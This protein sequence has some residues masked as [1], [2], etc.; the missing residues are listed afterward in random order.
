MNLIKLCTGDRRFEN[1]VCKKDDDFMIF[2][3]NSNLE[4]Y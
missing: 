1:R 2:Q 4:G 3:Y